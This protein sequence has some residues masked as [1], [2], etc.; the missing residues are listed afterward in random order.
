MK[1]ETGKVIQYYKVR[2]DLYG[3]LSQEIKNLSNNEYSKW[4][5]YKKERISK[6]DRDIFSVS[7]LSL[8][9]YFLVWWF[10]VTLLTFIVGQTFYS[11]V[12]APIRWLLRHG[13]AIAGIPGYAISYIA[14]KNAWSLLRELAMGLDGF[15]GRVPIVTKTPFYLAQQLHLYKD[16][17]KKAEERALERR[18]EWVDRYFGNIT[19]TF[20]Q[21]VVTSADL[22]ALLQIVEDDLS[23]VHAAY[24]TDDACITSIAQWIAEGKISVERP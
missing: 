8:L 21:M 18:K 10:L 2:V 16:M 23:L 9:G 24:Y 3:E 20:S 4:D 22:S 13:R 6:F 5:N 15:K 12:W 14:R 19:T 17:P 1:A 7:A 11:A